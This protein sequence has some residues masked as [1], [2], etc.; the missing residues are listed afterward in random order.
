[1]GYPYGHFR[2]GQHRYSYLADWWLE[3]PCENDKWTERVCLTPVWGI[4][5]PSLVNP[6]MAIE[7]VV[8]S[9]EPVEGPPRGQWEQVQAQRTKGHTPPLDRRQTGFKPARPG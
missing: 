7:G 2:Y 4:D 1:M 5:Q 8:G 9:M 3:R 6:W